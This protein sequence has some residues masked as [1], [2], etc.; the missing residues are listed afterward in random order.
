VLRCLETYEVAAIEDELRQA[1]VACAGIPGQTELRGNE[2][3]A[4]TRGE[5]I[6]DQLRGHIDEVLQLNL[7]IDL[8]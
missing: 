4:L 5:E 2:F 6:R 8:R 3:R 7:T 1:S